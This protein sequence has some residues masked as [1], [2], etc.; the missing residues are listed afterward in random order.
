MKKLCDA[1]KESCK[2]DDSAPVMNNSQS[3]YAG[4]TYG[5]ESLIVNLNDTGNRGFTI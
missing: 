5:K 2:N 4:L 1:Y 3:V